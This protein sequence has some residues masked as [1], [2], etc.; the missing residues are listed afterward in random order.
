MQIEDNDE[1]SV[2]E[3]NYLNAKYNY[4]DEA[5]P[6]VQAVQL[7]QALPL[8]IQ[9]KCRNDKGACQWHCM[10]HLNGRY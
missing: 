1:L 5:K 7:A 8:S 4:E 2:S 3:L 9:A 6:R 10:Y